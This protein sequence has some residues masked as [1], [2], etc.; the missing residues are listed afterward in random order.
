MMASGSAVPGVGTGE[1]LFDLGQFSLGDYLF[2]ELNQ[3]PFDFDDIGGFDLGDLFNEVNLKPE[4]LPDA[5]GREAE[6]ED[7]AV[8]GGDE[9]QADLSP[10][11]IPPEVMNLLMENV[12][13]LAAVQPGDLVLDLEIGRAHV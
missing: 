12:E 1:D 11:G 7:A 6:G 10:L 4:V 9:P 5:D 13:P 3:P 8:A 2:P